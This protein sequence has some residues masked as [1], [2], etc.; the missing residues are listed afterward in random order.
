MTDALFSVEKGAIRRGWCVKRVHEIGEYTERESSMA[1]SWTDYVN[2]GWVLL[3]ATV[4]CSLLLLPSVSRAAC[5]CGGDDG[6]PLTYSSPAT[7]PINIDG[8]L[9]DWG[10]ITADTDNNVCDGISGVD[11]L[12]SPNTGRDVV[13]F[14]FTYDDTWLYLYTE[15]TGSTSNTQTFLYYSDINNN[16]YMEELEPSIGVKWQGNNGSVDVYLMKYYA[17]D[18]TNGDSMVDTTT[19]LADG[20]SLPGYFQS[21]SGPISTLSGTYGSTDGLA[22]EFKIP[23]TAL[24]VTGPVAHSIHVAATNSNP[25][26]AD[27][28]SKI[29]DN[30]GGCGGGAGTTQYADLDFSGAYS[31]QGAQASTV[32]GL[33]HLEN[34]G[35]GDD[36]FSF[37]YTI[38]GPHSPTVTLYLDDGDAIF[39]T[40]DSVIPIAGTV[41]VATGA[42]VDIIIVYGIGPTALGTATVTTTATSEFSL[43]QSVTISDSVVDTVEVVMPDLVTIKSLSGVDDARAFNDTDSKAI[44]GAAVTYSIQVSNVG[45]GSTLSDSVVLTDRVPA[46]TEMYVGD[47]SASPVTWSE[48]GSGLAYSFVDLGDTGDD[49][50]F[51]SESGPAPAYTYT[52]GGADGYDSAVTGFRINPKGAFNPSSNFT[53]GPK[54]RVR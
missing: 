44:P 4:F 16:G 23:W 15:R 25:D 9:A 39:D 51:T 35:N 38:A 7:A 6:I 5:V 19:G 40:G 42:S 22:M 8:D 54:V 2:A 34:L 32:Y 49:I 20:Y 36:A 21:I 45:N 50:A 26:K 27:I 3:T 37:D 14:S 10:T 12:D 43:T 47:G 33:H 18:K 29:D 1:R 31:L 28:A 41:A 13:Q 48:S 11:D 53:L 46:G 24:G 52:P 17:I 30:L